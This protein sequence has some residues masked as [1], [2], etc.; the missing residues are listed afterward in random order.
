MAR[1]ARD[2]HG[3]AVRGASSFADGG[4]GYQPV[5][6]PTPEMFVELLTRVGCHIYSGEVIPGG[7]YNEITDRGR[8]IAVPGPL[9]EAGPMAR[10]CA[11]GEVQ[12]RLGLA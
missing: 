4:E 6:P 9:P 3:E 11:G 2:W 7:G 12:A 5:P 1:G 10:L 8:P